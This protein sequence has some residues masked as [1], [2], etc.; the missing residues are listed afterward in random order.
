[1]LQDAGMASFGKVLDQP[2]ATAIRAYV[3]HEANQA[4]QASASSQNTAR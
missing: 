1:V 2:T 3:I 4:R